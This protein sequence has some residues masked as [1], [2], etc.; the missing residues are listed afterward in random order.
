[1]HLGN[2]YIYPNGLRPDRRGQH[3]AL[4]VDVCQHAA[5]HVD[6]SFACIISIAR[7][8]N[9]AA[10]VKIRDEIHC[11][12]VVVRRP[13]LR[14]QLPHLFEQKGVPHINFGVFLESFPQGRY[15]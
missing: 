13:I 8:Y 9:T 3:A 14:N 15:P 12:N 7:F 11:N 5:L 4:L 1:M 6:L 10:A 2:I